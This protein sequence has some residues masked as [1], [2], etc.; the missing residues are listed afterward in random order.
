MKFLVLD[1]SRSNCYVCNR[2]KRDGLKIIGYKVDG[3]NR[4]LGEYQLGCYLTVDDAKAVY[5][6]MVEDIFFDDFTEYKMPKKEDKIVDNDDDNYK[7][8]E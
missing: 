6:N 3:Y 7:K 8:F 1:E 5:S 2:I 4:I